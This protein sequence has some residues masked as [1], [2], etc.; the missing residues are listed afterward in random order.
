MSVCAK[1]LLLWEIQPKQ[2]LSPDEPAP[3]LLE[4]SPGHPAGRTGC[5][6][7]CD[8]RRGSWLHTQGEDSHEIKKLGSSVRNLVIYEE[9]LLVLCIHCWGEG[10]LE[11]QFMCYP[12][13]LKKR[14]IPPLPLLIHLA[15][16]VWLTE[17]LSDICLGCHCSWTSVCLSC[18]CLGAVPAR[19]VTVPAQLLGPARAAAAAAR[20][21]SATLAALGWKTD[22]QATKVRQNHLAFE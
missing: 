17:I 7:V 8:T 9:A 4:G 6:V 13:A 16:P 18:L 19:C 15:E 22:F 3:M 10:P 20:V 2:N 14:L 12:R 1:T 5:T 11:K 21:R